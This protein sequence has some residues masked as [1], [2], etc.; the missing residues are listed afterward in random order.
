MLFVCVTTSTVPPQLCELQSSQIA[1]RG[2]PSREFHP[3]I[4]IV[5]EFRLR[6][7]VVGCCTWLRHRAGSSLHLSACTNQRRIALHVQ[8]HQG[9]TASRC[10]ALSQSRI[11][12]YVFTRSCGLLS[13]GHVLGVWYVATA[14]NMWSLFARIV[15][16]MHGPSCELR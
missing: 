12:R 4:I 9:D 6:C 5:A 14:L 3:C 2:S 10:A 11:S 1:C 8:G 15:I 16:G 7:A 13:T